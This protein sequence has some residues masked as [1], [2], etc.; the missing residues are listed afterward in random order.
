MLHLRGRECSCSL[1]NTNC[2]NFFWLKS[3]VLVFLMSPLKELSSLVFLKKLIIFSYFANYWNQLKYSEINFLGGQRESRQPPSRGCWRSRTTR[4]PARPS[5]SWWPSTASR[6]FRRS[7]TSYGARTLKSEE[8]ERTFL[9][10]SHLMKRD[11]HSMS[12]KTR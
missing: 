3:F 4:W 9:A 10:N 6:Y 5:P 11:C 1:Q 2:A 8:E 7:A 12:H